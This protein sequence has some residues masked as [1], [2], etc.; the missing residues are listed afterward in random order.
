VI[1]K[2]RKTD[3]TLRDKPVRV[4]LKKAVLHIENDR[5]MNHLAE[6]GIGA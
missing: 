4:L 6:H 5:R 2:F 3:W 1:R